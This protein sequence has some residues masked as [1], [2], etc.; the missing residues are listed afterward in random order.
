M[1]RDKGKD[2]VMSRSMERDQVGN[3]RRRPRSLAQGNN[4]LEEDECHFS[5]KGRPLD[6]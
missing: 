2:S 5:R 4:I 1:K 6:I 3:L